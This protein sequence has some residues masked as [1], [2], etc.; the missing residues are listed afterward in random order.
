MEGMLLLRRTGLL[1]GRQTRTVVRPDLYCARPRIEEG[2][3]LLLHARAP[4][5]GRLLLTTDPV[6]ALLTA[7]LLLLAQGSLLGKGGRANG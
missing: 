2:P 4:T 7:L 6:V 5:L 1:R 3:S